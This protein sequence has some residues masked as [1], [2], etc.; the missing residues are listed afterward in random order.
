MGRRP[1]IADDD[2]LAAAH[3]AFVEYGL[4][5]STRDIARR[6][7]VSEGVLFQRHGTKANLF[8]AAMAPP[9]FRW[10]R[11]FSARRLREDGRARLEAL[12]Q[13]LIEYF[14]QTVPVLLP[15]LSHPEFRFEEFARR[16]P[17][18]SL[19]TLRREI[20]H[21]LASERAVGRLGPIDPGPAALALMSLGHSVAVFERLGAHG[22]R[23]PEVLVRGAV[24]S[25]WRGFAPAPARQVKTRRRDKRL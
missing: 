19:I 20:V 21:H 2:I 10:D 15:L 1:T 25:I 24:A 16:H 5:A 17:G 7:G 13:S 22:R 6:A 4:A 9:P 8:F 12:V 11:V 23:F 18:S 3:E 14:R